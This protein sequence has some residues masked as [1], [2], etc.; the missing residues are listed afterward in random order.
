MHR[1]QHGKQHKKTRQRGSRYKDLHIPYQNQNFISI[2]R[3]NRSSKTIIA[4]AAK[5]RDKTNYCTF[6]RGSAGAR[7]KLQTRSRKKTST[8]QLSGIQSQ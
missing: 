8:G 1:K 5:K 3:S 6:G 7:E 2:S 4:I